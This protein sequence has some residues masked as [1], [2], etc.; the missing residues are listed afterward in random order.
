MPRPPATAILL[1]V[2]V[3]LCLPASST[4]GQERDPCDRPERHDRPIDVALDDLAVSAAYKGRVVRAKGVVET[5]LDPS[6]RRRYVLR[7]SLNRVGL[8]P[9]PRVAAEFDDLASGRPRLEVTGFVSEEA[10]S[11]PDPMAP[12][13]VVLVWAFADVSAAEQPRREGAGVALR[14]LL[15]DGDAQVG[16]KVRV[17]G[18]FG[19]RN[20]LGDLPAASAPEPSAWVLRDGRHAVWVV[21][22]RPEGSGFK[23][24]PDYA[25]DAARWLVVEGKLERCGAIFC[26]RARRVSLSGPG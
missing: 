10:G 20:L 6:G 1:F 26:L 9:C 25:P 16:K 15:Q 2:S 14:D 8:V 19:G 17:V 4:S 23:L 13:V 7:E 11:A 5:D 24:D 18:Q 3:W 22:R 21:G 12:S